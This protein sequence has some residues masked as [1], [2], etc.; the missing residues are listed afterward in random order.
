MFYKCPFV[1]MHN[2]WQLRLKVNQ[3]KVSERRDWQHC[4][5]VSFARGF[6]CFTTQFPTKRTVICYQIGDFQQRYKARRN[7]DEKRVSTV[8]RFSN[9]IKPRTPHGPFHQTRSKEAHFPGK[10][11]YH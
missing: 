4:P 3:T 2:I 9:K 5:R 1:Q 8:T 11:S 10:F 7:I 6:G